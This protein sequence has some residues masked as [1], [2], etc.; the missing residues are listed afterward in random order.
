MKETI[1]PRYYSIERL[2][3]D[4]L[5]FVWRNLR[6]Y[7][8]L[9]LTLQGYDDKN[10]M[11]ALNN[12]VALSGKYR[13]DPFCVFGCHETEGTVFIWFFATNDFARHWRKIHKVSTQF[14]QEVRQ[15]FPGKHVLVEV[16]EAH[17]ESMRWLKRIGF[18]RTNHYRVVKGETLRILEWRG[19][20]KRLFA[21]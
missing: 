9:E 4:D 7:D 11:R 17:E 1:N 19:M 18:E 8:L 5:R 14:I 10:V 21:A 15:R 3:R 20:E 12:P 13:S 16:W 6:L 2:N